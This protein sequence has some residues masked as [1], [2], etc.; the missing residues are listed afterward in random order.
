L[1]SD[2]GKGSTLGLLPG[3]AEHASAA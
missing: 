2:L 3:K 1:H